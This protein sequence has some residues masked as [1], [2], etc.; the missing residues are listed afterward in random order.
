MSI[1]GEYV[2]KPETVVVSRVDEAIAPDAITV[3]PT[4]PAVGPL[5]TR[6]RT[7]DPAI[8]ESTP[9]VKLSALEP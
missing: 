7:T 2:P 3:L 1:V 4:V 9:A 5:K 6:A 8:A